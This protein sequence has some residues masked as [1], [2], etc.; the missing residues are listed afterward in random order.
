MGRGCGK[1]TGGLP[2]QE[3]P[4]QADLQVGF[5]LSEWFPVLVILSLRQGQNCLFSTRRNSIRENSAGN[6]D[7]HSPCFSEGP[8]SGY[9]SELELCMDVGRKGQGAI[10]ETESFTTWPRIKLGDVCSRVS[11]WKNLVPEKMLLLKWL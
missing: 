10:T 9:R 3:A 11:P 1:C 4:T 5:P 8:C 2:G 6:L 7:H